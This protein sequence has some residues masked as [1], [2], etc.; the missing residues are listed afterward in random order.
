MLFISS[1]LV[2]QSIYGSYTIDHEIGIVVG[3]T[4]TS[5]GYSINVIEISKD[6]I[7]I[8]NINKSIKLK[9]ELLG[10]SVYCPATKFIKPLATEYYS[11]SGKFKKDSLVLRYFAAS[12]I[13]EKYEGLLY[14]G[15][16]KKS[17]DSLNNTITSTNM[18]SYNVVKIANPF[19]EFLKIICQSD[20]FDNDTYPVSLSLINLYGVSVLQSDISFK[21]ETTSHFETSTLSNGIYFCNLKFRNQQQITIRILKE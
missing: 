4:I 7:Y 15:K 14:A 9:C 8:E 10:D 20:Y 5:S 12:T 11:A 13:S 3:A 17:S 16:E 19:S 21:N 2:G 18:R 1:T 6:S